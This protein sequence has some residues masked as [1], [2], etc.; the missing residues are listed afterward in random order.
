MANVNNVH[1]NYKICKQTSFVSQKIFSINFV[2]I[3]EIKPVLTFD[4]PI[5]VGFSILYLSNFLKHEFHYK[6]IKTKYNV[7]LLFTD[8]DSLVLKQMMLMKIVMG[9]KIYLILVITQKIQNFLILSI[10]KLLIK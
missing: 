8:T 2:A 7:Y 4:K 3:H 5:Y 9:K 10:K 1:V 6:Y